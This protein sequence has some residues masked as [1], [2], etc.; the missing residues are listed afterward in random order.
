MLVHFADEPSADSESTT[1]ARGP[2]SP[3]VPVTGMRG[4]A[5]W[6][7]LIVTGM[8]GECNILSLRYGK[9]NIQSFLPQTY[10]G[11]GKFNTTT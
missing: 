2:A 3:A 11:L 8:P 1:E 10:P 5:E 7:I 4:P 9:D 6:K